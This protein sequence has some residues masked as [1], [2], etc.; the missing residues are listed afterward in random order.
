MQ[1]I[2]FTIFL[3]FII[4]TFSKV[5]NSNDFTKFM[6]DFSVYCYNGISSP[7]HYKAIAKKEGWKTLSDDQKVMLRNAR[8]D[9]F[10]GY[11]YKGEDKS[12]ITMIG[13]GSARDKGE[14]M[15]SCSLINFNSDYKTNVNQMIKHF[16]AKKIKDFHMGVQYMELFRVDLPAFKKSIIST[17]QDKSQ[18]EG[19]DL[20]KFD[21]LVYE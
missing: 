3:I 17:N 20:F 12:D 16:N 13:F 11:A 10:D 15:H 21:L 8:G 18:S 4:S 7:L 2:K 14:I 6:K 19:K 1:Q 5:A 9:D